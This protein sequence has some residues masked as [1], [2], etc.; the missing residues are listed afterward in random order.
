[1]RAQVGDRLNLRGKIVGQADEHC[2]IIEIL[3]SDGQPPY[4]VRHD[5]GHEGIMVPGA[6]AQLEPRA[7]R[8]ET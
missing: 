5:D 4:R 1:M 7:S 3:G 8:D 2:E 6:D